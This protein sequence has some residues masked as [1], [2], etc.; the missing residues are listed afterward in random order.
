MWCPLIQR[1]AVVNR[2]Q[3]HG[4]CIARRTCIAMAPRTQTSRHDEEWEGFS[5]LE[6]KC[7]ENCSENEEKPKKMKRHEWRIQKLP[8]IC[9][10]S[11]RGARHLITGIRLYA[12][13]PRL[14]SPVK[15]K[16]KEEK[17]KKWKSISKTEVSPKLDRSISIKSQIEASSRQKSLYEIKTE[18][19]PWSQDRS[20]AMKSR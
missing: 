1:E 12:W 19:S 11:L 18:V 8:R 17:E 14:V 4:R 16:K 13:G 20:V 6:G 3:V 15:K 9:N 5:V 10:R 7:I 2:I